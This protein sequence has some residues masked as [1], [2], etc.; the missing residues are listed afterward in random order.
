MLYD[1]A[2]YEDRGKF[3]MTRFN[4][5]CLAEYAEVF[6]TVCVDAAYYTF[7][8]QQ[9]LEGM[10]NQTPDDF[11][12]GLKVTDAIT[13]KK[14]PKLDRFGDMAGKPKESYL[15]VDE[16]A[17]SY[18]IRNLRIRC[19]EPLSCDRRLRHWENVRVVNIFRGQCPEDFSIFGP[20]QTAI[21]AMNGFYAVTVT[22][23]TRALVL[24]ARLPKGSCCVPQHVYR[25]RLQLGVTFLPIHT[26]LESAGSPHTV[27]IAPPIRTSDGRLLVVRLEPLHRVV[28]QLDY[29]SGSELGCC[30]SDD[31]QLVFQI[32]SRPIQAIHL[33]WSQATE[34][35]QDEVRGQH[36]DFEIPG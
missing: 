24:E 15:N 28:S 3:A 22:I 19:Y 10:V 16:H 11:R 12:F 33:L 9:Y 7:P 27:K 30:S 21:I 2:R 8:S 20:D 36:A 26:A 34:Q 32:H 18:Y 4:R 5:E 31:D 14:F 6:K 13:I 35:R 23:R 25:P 29:T 1:R 17:G